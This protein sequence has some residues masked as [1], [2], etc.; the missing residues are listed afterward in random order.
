MKE[1][2]KK[3]F[4]D[5]L[6]ETEEEGE[7]VIDEPIKEVK[8][9]EKAP[10]TAE[11]QKFLY[12]KKQPNSFISVDKRERRENKKSEVSSRYEIKPNIS[13]MFGVVGKNSEPIVP[14]AKISNVSNNIKKSKEIQM[15]KFY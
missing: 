14:D 9:E 10:A 11:A 4:L 5:I 13:P 6:F 12:N 1:E 7:V 2:I 3:K 15:Q 8:L